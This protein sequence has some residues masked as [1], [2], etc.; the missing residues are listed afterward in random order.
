M[1][2]LVG[3]PLLCL[4]V[5]TVVSL[6][7][8]ASYQEP[9][10][11][12]DSLSTHRVSYRERLLP[13]L[14]RFVWHHKVWFLV[15]CLYPI[16]STCGF[17]LLNPLLVDSGWQLDQIGFATKIYGSCIGLLSAMLATPLMSWLGR[18]NAL[19]GVILIQ[20]LALFVLL[21]ITQGNA[22]SL[23][24]Y[25]YITAHF[26]GFPALLVISSTIMMDK[27]AQTRHRATFFTLQFTVASLLGLVYSSVSLGL[28]NRYGYDQ[29]A[30]IGALLTL[31][32]M[33]FV[34]A[35]LRQIG[36][37]KPLLEASE[38]RA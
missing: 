19:I 29:V 34:G 10:K 28:A 5:L 8:I 38:G 12:A 32:I 2:G 22:T 24:V 21:P 35:A 37:S 36:R 1:A 9:E 16:G 23:Y 20:A 17:A 13:A 18:V 14:A 33:A 15:M 25:S 4:A 11:G 3:F 30:L 27:A 26:I 31:G 6:V 7:Q